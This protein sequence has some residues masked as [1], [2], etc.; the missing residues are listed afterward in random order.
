M[1]EAHAC[2]AATRPDMARNLEMLGLMER[3]NEALAAYLRDQA[4]WRWMRAMQYPRDRR[5]A[6]WAQATERAANYVERLPAD[7][8][9]LRTIAA[10]QFDRPDDFVVLGGR[11]SQFAGRCDLPPDK[12]LTRLAQIVAEEAAEDYA[13]T[14]G[15]DLDDRGDSPGL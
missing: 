3:I 10:A 11:S 14:Y 2:F 7:D 12:F 13:G 9:R 5:Q 15:D 6:Q 8:P 4:R 1:R